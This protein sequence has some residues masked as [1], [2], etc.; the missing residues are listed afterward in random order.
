MNGMVQPVE[1]SDSLHVASSQL[2]SAAS[3]STSTS[4]NES[5]SSH[6]VL[7]GISSRSTDGAR[8]LRS[9]KQR[10][11]DRCRQRKSRCAIAQIGQ[12]CSECHQTGNPCTFLLPP[13][14]RP[15]KDIGPSILDPPPPPSPALPL[16]APNPPSQNLSSPPLFPSNQSASTSQERSNN[17]P[18]AL[19]ERPVKRLRPEAPQLREGGGEG[20]ER[21]S[22]EFSLDSDLPPDV[23]PT[24]IT[25]TLTDD[26]LTNLGSGP[27]CKMVSS[28][29]HTTFI[30]FSR[31]PAHRSTSHEIETTTLGQLRS[32]IAFATRSKDEK[33]LFA[34]FVSHVNPAFPVLSL[35][36]TFDDL[37]PCLQAFVL[38]ESVATLPE[39]RAAGTQAR[40]MIKSARLADKMLETQAK[41]SSISA[42]LLELNMNL[43]PR[44]D[45]LL[46]SKTIA[47][48][49]LLGLHID[50]QGWAI[51]ESEKELRTKLW[52]LL[53]IQDAWS[54]FLNSRPSH[55]QHG[56]TSVP[57]PLF[58]TE[59]G[60][61]KVAFGCACRLGAVVAR[62][63][64]EVSILDR[65]GNS[66]R[67]DSCDSIETDLNT[68]KEGLREYYEL[69]TARTAGLDSVLFLVLAL[70]CM[71]RRI[72]IEIRIGI[73]SAF[74]PD[75][76]T[77]SIFTELVLFVEKLSV[78]SHELVYDW[79]GYSS[80][81][82]S[83][84]LSSLVR[85]SLAYTANTSDTSPV[86]SSS[87]PINLLARLVQSLNR[88]RTTHAFDLVEGALSRA[89]NVVARL[90]TAGPSDF[91][92]IIS[93]LRGFDP[94]SSQS[95][96][97]EG[98]FLETLASLA[99]EPTLT[100]FD[101][102]NPF[103]EVPADVESWMSVL[104]ERPTWEDLGAIDW[105]LFS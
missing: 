21:G 17:E 3:A 65:Y 102:V 103:A 83:S 4:Q 30:T 10:P 53:R 34:R 70:R 36:S 50:C 87:P 59:S 101:T 37:Q 23:E 41:L 75:Q 80:H 44:G 104:D 40:K 47:H 72:S 61:D 99:A 57:L 15:K 45:F 76:S 81:I 33:E 28:R 71:V 43:D 85:L 16:P 63:Q 90:T 11:C 52:W 5:S 97:L 74:N 64:R 31:K 94:T 29:S 42:A 14:A 66:Q 2:S 38:V 55:L 105:N 18:R 95:T 56:N 60:I 7:P 26:L 96:S 6:E 62:L 84:V 9:K 39:F 78:A 35:S 48:A 51:P 19:A 92:T 67:I 46:L 91:Q 22:G 98:S 24:T 20:S 79:P 82:F 100:N 32:F 77:L 93:A 27:P 88:L 69:E 8:P 1:N 25:A 73:G 12:P 58:V 54:S 86:T 68:M 89:E 49:Q 13:P